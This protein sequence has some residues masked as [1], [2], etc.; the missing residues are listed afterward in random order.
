M[1]VVMNDGNYMV[2]RVRTDT[3]HCA[4]QVAPTLIVLFLVST[5]DQLFVLRPR[6]D[7][8]TSDI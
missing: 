2:S 1:L 3:T 4:W 8:H 7:L 5:S 6:R